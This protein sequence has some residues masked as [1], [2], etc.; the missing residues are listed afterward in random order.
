MTTPS[1]F[2]PLP[3]F[4]SPII[5][6]LT[7]STDVQISR[8]G[9]ERRT[10]WKAVPHYDYEW[11]TFALPGSQDAAA[12]AAQTTPALFSIPLWP[13]AAV[14]DVPDLMPCW[15]SQLNPIDS[16]TAALPLVSTL[17]GYSDGSSPSTFLLVVDSRQNLVW[18]YGG[19]P[20]NFPRD[21]GTRPPFRLVAPCASGYLS[22]SRSAS[23]VTN[24]LATYKVVANLQPYFEQQS[25]SS[26]VD[27][28][29]KKVYPQLSLMTD[30][31]AASVLAGAAT[32]LVQDFTSPAHEQ[33]DDSVADIVTS[34]TRAVDYRYTK[35]SVS[36]DVT[37]FS[38]A[39]I[40]A[41]RRFLFACRGR[42]AS[43]SWQA[44]QDSVPHTWRLASDAIEISYTTTAVA[45]TKLKLT[46][47]A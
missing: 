25:L 13:H 1:I 38:R 20:A 31:D 29:G 28:S 37:C 22:A 7:W 41:L 45:R 2:A 30:D 33:Q 34:T 47:L 12:L 17:I 36:I 8:N 4:S 9:T 6:R 10:Q 3:D 15:P 19:L 40:L 32:V 21:S 18:E 35:R 26:G 24:Q 46:Q 44:P 43:F 5:E 14:Q 23:W 39:E 42:F 27:S 11:S 16:T